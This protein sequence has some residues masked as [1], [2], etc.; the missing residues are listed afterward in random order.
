M[1]ELQSVFSEDYPGLT[2]RSKEL[3]SEHCDAIQ[4]NPALA[5]TFGVKRTCLLISLQLFHTSDNFAV[6]IMHNLLE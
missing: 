1:R 5:S 2:L 3:H 6:D 4:Q